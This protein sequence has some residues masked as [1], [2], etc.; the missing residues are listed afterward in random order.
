MPERTI[1]AYLD[2]PYHIEIVRDDSGE[3]PGWMARVLEF[4]GCLTQAENFEDLGQLVREAMRGWIEIGLEDGQPIPEPFTDEEYSGKF[5]VRVP[6][7]LHR[8]LVE[9]A[10]QD[11]VSLNAF[12]NVVLAKAVGPQTLPSRQRAPVRGRV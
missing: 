4:P 8:Q 2:L 7:S 12:V 6:R 5:V 11:G 1:E 9:A 3:Q 10:K